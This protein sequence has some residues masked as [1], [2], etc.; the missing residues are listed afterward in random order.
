MTTHIIRDAQQRDF[1]SIVELNKSFVKF[2]SEMDLQR[3]ALLDRLSCYHRVVEDQGKVVAFL[4]ALD[5]QQDYDSVNYQWFRRNCSDFIY[6]DRIVIDAA[7]QGKG[8]GSL[9]YQ[10]IFDLAKNK[11][12]NVL[13]ASL[14]YS[15][16]MLFRL[17]FIRDLASIR[18]APKYSQQLKK[19]FLCKS[20]MFRTLCILKRLTWN[21]P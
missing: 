13:P 14:I 11:L 10:D 8:L 18:S 12:I 9:L 20:Q 15:R 7:Q 19:R 17:G 5:G 2:T 1:P 21:S 16:P 3:T 6:I 4:L